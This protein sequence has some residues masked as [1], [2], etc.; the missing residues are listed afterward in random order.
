MTPNIR[1]NWAKEN[2]GD[3]VSFPIGIGT[4]GMFKTGKMPWLWGTPRSEKLVMPSG[5][6]PTNAELPPDEI[7]SF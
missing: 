4:I 6:R 7:S 2:S 5:T 3:L 1:I